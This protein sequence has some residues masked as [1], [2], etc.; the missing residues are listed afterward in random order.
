MVAL[1]SLSGISLGIAKI[2]DGSI[3]IPACSKQKFAPCTCCNKKSKRIHSSYIRVLRDLPASTHCVSINLTVR[4]FFCKNPECERK[5]FT[6][7]PGP[8]IKAYSRMTNRT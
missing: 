3:S 5:I 2:I 6:E 7:Q 1:F 8:E 4:K